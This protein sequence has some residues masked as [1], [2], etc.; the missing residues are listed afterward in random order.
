[1]YVF[2][3]YVVAGVVNN[4]LAKGNLAEINKQTNNSPLLI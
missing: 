2:F 4:Q 3:S 1:M